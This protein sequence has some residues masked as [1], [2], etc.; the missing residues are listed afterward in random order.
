MLKTLLLDFTTA[1]NLIV[2]LAHIQVFQL[3][4]QSFFTKKEFHILK[5]IDCDSSNL[6]Y[7]INCNKCGKQYVGETGR[8]LKYRFTEHLRDLKKN[9]DTTVA[10]HFN[11]ADHSVEDI[12]ILGIDLLFKS[13]N[14]REHKEQ[15]WINK[16]NTMQPVGLKIKDWC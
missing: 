15:L 1:P 5:S 3:F 6:I 13:D 14:Y 16:L 2:L 10:I 11:M 8:K 12:S 9:L 7:L 4:F